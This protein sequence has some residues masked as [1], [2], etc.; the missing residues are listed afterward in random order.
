MPAD[1]LVYVV[2]DDSAVNQLFVRIVETLG[3]CAV[4]CPD[5]EAFW[6]AL[7]RS[8]PGCVLADIELPGMSGL[9]I[10]SRLQSEQTSIPVI[11]ITGHA[12]VPLC[13]SAMQRGAYEFLEKPPAF[14]ALG[15]SIQRAVAHSRSALELAGQPGSALAWASLSPTPLTREELAIL[16]LLVTGKANKQ[17]AA[18]LDVSVRTV[19]LRVTNL[20]RKLG[21][22][23]RTALVHQLLHSSGLETRYRIDAAS[24]SSLPP[25]RAAAAPQTDA[26]GASHPAADRPWS[27]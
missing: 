5:G 26:A 18:R 23:S 12:S 16:D 14:G 7:D 9:D 13:V 24:A 15:A 19:Q 17:I 21:A 6:V 10:L 27:S 11:L 20:M 8:T 1:G 4:S 22:E 2:E 3:L 25:N